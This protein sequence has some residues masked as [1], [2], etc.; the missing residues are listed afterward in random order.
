MPPM[1]MSRM[2]MIN[3]RLLPYYTVILW[4]DVHTHTKKKKREADHKNFNK[5]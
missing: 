3:I 1:R 5:T 4:T 2:L